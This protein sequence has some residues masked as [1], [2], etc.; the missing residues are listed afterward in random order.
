MQRMNECQDSSLIAYE[1]PREQTMQAS[2]EIAVRTGL[3]AAR[4]R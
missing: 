1:G 3:K 2:R 4:A